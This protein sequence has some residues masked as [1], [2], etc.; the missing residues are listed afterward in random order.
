MFIHRNQIE[1]KLFIK[2]KNLDF[3][4]FMLIKYFLLKT[5]LFDLKSNKILVYFL[6]INY[7]HLHRFCLLNYKNKQIVTGY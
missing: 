5:Y 7:I 3:E 4:N 2:M 6:E 1:L